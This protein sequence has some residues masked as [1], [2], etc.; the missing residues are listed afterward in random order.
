MAGS[1][2]VGG[3]GLSFARQGGTERDGHGEAI[4]RN[5]ALGIAFACLAAGA[6]AALGLV[7]SPNPDGR[8]ERLGY[9]AA[10]ATQSAARAQARAKSAQ[11]RTAQA[12]KQLAELQSRMTLLAENGMVQEAEDYREAEAL[13]ISRFISSESTALWGDEK[14]RVMAAIVREGRRNRLDPVMVAAVIQVESHFNPYAISGAGACGLM[15]LMAPTAQALLP[16]KSSKELHLRASHLF[17]PVLNIELGTAYLAQLMKRF[18]GDM[19]MTLIAYNA[20]PGVARSLVRNSA[21]SKRLAVYPKAVLAAYRQML[22][23]P[24]ATQLASR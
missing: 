22:T 16:V 15:Q 4:R 13:G 8:A 14:R 2:M 20:G 23:A 1:T 11:A 12:E 9:L 18:D 6:G 21:A 24:Q 19:S 17:N 10:A 7:A 5:R 3:G